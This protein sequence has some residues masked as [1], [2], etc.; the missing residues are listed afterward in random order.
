MAEERQ[1]LI[2]AQ[3]TEDDLVLNLS[4]RPTKLHEFIGQKDMVENLKVCLLYTS[5][6]PRD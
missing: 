1:K 4:L 2:L 5:P 6:S 3:E